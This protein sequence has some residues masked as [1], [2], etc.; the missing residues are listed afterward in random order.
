MT[1]FSDTICRSNVFSYFTVEVET[2]RVATVS[3]AVEVESHFTAQVVSTATQVLSTAGV[4]SGATE[5][6]QDANKTAKADIRITFFIL[7]CW[8]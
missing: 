4:A 2:V 7:V 8:F 3:V 5:L 6:E 1:A